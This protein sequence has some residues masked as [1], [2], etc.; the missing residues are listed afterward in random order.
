[1]DYR[2]P[3][4]FE[5]DESGRVVV[6]FADLPEAL[7]D[8]GDLAEALSEA[9]DCLSAALASRIIDGEAIPA[10]S[11]PAP[12]QRLVSP[13][14]TIVLKAALYSEIERREMTVADLADLLGMGDWHQ[15][16]RLIDPRRSS[17]LTSLATALGAL[18]CR[19]AVSVE[20]PEPAPGAIDERLAAAAGGPREG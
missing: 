9:A 17:K 14:P 16:A 13:D 2:Y 5:P 15:A 19:V 8:G 18:G 7:T 11:S 4:T 3:A 20:G 12:G 6:R 1:M 10:A